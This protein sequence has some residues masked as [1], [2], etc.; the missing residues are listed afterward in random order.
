M[1]R[2]L[3]N[4][5]EQG[6]AP[7]ETTRRDF[8][9]LAT[10]MAAGAIIGQPTRAQCV[11]A[12]SGPVIGR[13]LPMLLPERDTYR[14]LSPFVSPGK[15]AFASEQAAERI[16]AVLNRLTVTRSLPLADK[17]RGRSPL[18]LLYDRVAEDVYKAKFGDT[19]FRGQ[20]ARFQAE[21]ATW[22]G[23]CGHVRRAQFFVLPNNR[24][25]Y[26]ISSEDSRGLHYRVGEWRQIWEDTT[27]VGFSPIEEIRTTAS[28]PFF[29]D[30]TA[31]TFGRTESFQQQLLRGANHWR[32]GLDVATGI[33]I[34]AENG[35]AVGDIDGDGWDE[36]YVCQ[37]GGLPNRLYKNQGGQ[38]MV[39]IS[40]RAGVAVL[41]NTSCALFLDLRNVGQQDLVV[42]T[43]N[44][45][46]LFLNQGDGTFVQ[47]PRAFRF[48]TDMTGSFTG[49]A[50]ADY[51]NDG[52][53]DLYICT[54]INF[55]TKEEYRYP[56]P[57]YDAR[58][59]PPNFLFR[60]R[61]TAD[62]EG[63]FEDVTDAV[64]LSQ[65]NDRFSFA[66]AWCDYNG[67]GWPD[68]YVANDFGLKN[69]YRN[70]EGHFRDVAVEAG[71]E[72]LGPGM[73][74]AWFDYDGDGRFDLY[75][76]NMWTDTGQ[77]VADSPAFHPD[78]DATVRA[79]FRRHA[80]GN[81]LFHNQGDG[82]FVETDRSEGVEMGRWSWGSDGLDFDNDGSPEIYIATG[83]FTNPSDDDLQGFF[84]R[85]VIARSPIKPGDDEGPY[86]DGWDVLNQLARERHSWS[87]RQPNVFYVRR[88]GH[89]YDFS[90]VSGLDFAE[91]T[92]AFAALDLDGDGSLD[93]LVKNR[94]GPQVRAL[95]ND[96]G[97]RRTRLVLR[98]HGTRSNR[99]AIGA[100]VEVRTKTV[101]SLQFVRA[102]SGFLSQH[103][104]NLHFGMADDVLAELVRIK[105]P[106]GQVQ[107]FNNLPAGFIYDLTEGATDAVRHE[108]R[109]RHWADGLANVCGENET[110]DNPTWLLEPVLLPDRRR[111]PGLL[112][113][114]DDR[115]PAPPVG[116]PVEIIKATNDG[117]NGA[118]AMYGVL[119]KYLF[120]YRADPVLPIAFLID[121]VGLARR[122]YPGLPE[123]SALREDLARLKTADTGPLALPFGGK[124]YQ[125]THREYF[126]LGA[127]FLW[128]GYAE[129][130][131]TFFEEAIRRSPNDFLGHMILGELQ[132]KAG[133]VDVASRHLKE[134]IR[135]RPTSADAWNL[136][137]VLDLQKENYASALS[138]FQ[139]VL[140]IDPTADYAL[141][142]CGM[143][144]AKTGDAAD[145]ENMFRRALRKGEHQAEAA[146]QLGILLADQQ[147]FGEA[148]SYFERA[149]TIKRDDIDAINNLGV[150][151]IKA[152]QFDNAIVAFRYGLQVAPEDETL[153]VNL[154]TAYSRAGDPSK[155]RE[156]LL[157]L[158]AR[159]ESSKARQLLQELDQP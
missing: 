148:R 127:A 140:A 70:H 32:A 13:K 100:V 95:R 24:V 120:D 156:V 69:L 122:V 5:A 3:P 116:W 44:G 47:K 15:D 62:G 25:R 6:G 17:F 77:R 109:T 42:L 139:H 128:S 39:D 159:K 29:T 132:L 72:D 58:T 155:A 92:R 64:G 130:A 55:T 133:R 86:A 76:S 81:S 106:S 142:N 111:G 68:L 9:R 87:G 153:S 104:K 114:V 143:A 83:M 10:A 131:T 73:S 33:D 154:A 27:L 60:N 149:I 101:R 45:P 66:P 57:F 49:M 78:A 22:I 56:K 108:L 96:W 20:D 19:E 18:P 52:L 31:V 11:P 30:V 48:A 152:H 147:R 94:C 21:L 28:R 61:L 93:L 146:N 53:L 2:N 8:L 65:N 37:S 54:Y 91:D 98:L 7:S 35:I 129:A 117:T 4:L 103:T 107:E 38:E 105:W 158:L 1:D 115:S 16:T 23:C 89:F 26:E 85:Q 46:L 71:V 135:L 97:T 119:R 67:D 34:Y 14:H 113:V 150:L 118:G 151:Y 74:A 124:Y 123:A 43:T 84:W 141:V 125:Q 121:D 79:A 36:V 138:D 136:L 157:R 144:Y 110:L 40:E 80:K 59:G 41:D 126:R 102:G 50:A 90:S 63:Y 75:V 145:A 137:G 12:N 99:D 82:T 134:A 112:Y 51:D 88:N